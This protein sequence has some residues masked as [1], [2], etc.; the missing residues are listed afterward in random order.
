[1]K[2]HVYLILGFVLV[3]GGFGVGLMLAVAG[4]PGTGAAVLIGGCVVGYITAASA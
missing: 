4:F 2:K 1:M 3:F